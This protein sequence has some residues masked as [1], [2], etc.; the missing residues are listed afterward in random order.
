MN[1]G[2]AA[3]ITAAASG[4]GARRYDQSLTSEQRSGIENGIWV[5]RGCDGIIDRDEVRFTRSVLHSLR[6]DHT[7]FARLGEQRDN[8]VG[9]I[10]IGPNIYAGGQVQNLNGQ[11]V[12][13]QL[14]FFL[15]GTSNDLFSYVSQ[16]SSFH[17]LEQYVVISELGLGGLLSG[18]PEIERNGPFWTLNFTWDEPAPRRS[19]SELT[20]MC[21]NT[22]RFIEGAQYWKQTF[23]RV[24]G[25]PTRSWFANMEGGSHLS[26]LYDALRSSI[27][28]EHLLKCELTR[29]SSVPAAAHLG[30][31][32]SG[33][34][35][36]QC[37][38]HVRDVSVPS[39][40]LEN[41]RFAVNVEFDLQG[42]GRWSDTLTVFVYDTEMLREER[43]KA[44]WMTENIRR[45]DGGERQLP[46]P[47]PPDGWM[48]DDGFPK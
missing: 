25:Q 1:V 26:E 45:I 30:S 15:N 20:G 18:S 8:D 21:E 2:I 5:C 23:Q 10:A 37:V 6:R 38:T 28:F 9:I 31:A 44:L 29:L 32:A 27:W 39:D 4:P 35:P 41:N 19:A 24:L 12:S 48:P 7:E 46:T 43:A 14:T 22:G 11:N 33:H 16:F 47:I 13:F 34:P 17:R 40:T 3:H 42:Y 36:F